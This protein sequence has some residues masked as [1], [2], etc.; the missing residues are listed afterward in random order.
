MISIITAT[1]NIIA[2]GRKDSLRRCIES[3]SHLECEHI[4]CDGGSPDGTVDFVKSLLP[5]FPNLRLD[6]KMDTGVYAAFNRGVSLAGGKWVYFLGSDDYL[7]DPETLIEA[8]REAESKKAEMIVSPVVNSD[9]AAGFKSRRDCGNI[10]IIKP[11]CH[12]GVLMTKSL[13]LRLGGFNESYRIASDFELCLKAHLENMSC[14]FSDKCYASFSAGNGLSMS[15]G[16]ERNERLDISQRLLGIPMS[17]QNLFFKKQLLPYK[18]I[19]A[20][21]CHKNSVIRQGA[22]YAFARR[23]ANIIGLLNDEGGPKS[24]F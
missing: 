16:G 22:R 9:G 19:F 4:I 23:A 7:T 21:M 13:I 18:I 3:V 24:W 20:L 11:Y 6:S 15:G 14:V 5:A 10:L 1:K 17:A 12:Q 2:G 8:A